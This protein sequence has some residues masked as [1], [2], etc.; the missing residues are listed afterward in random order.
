MSFDATFFSFTGGE[1]EEGEEEEERKTHIGTFAF[2]QGPH[3]LCNLGPILDG[4]D[5]TKIV[6]CANTRNDFIL[7]SHDISRRSKRDQDIFQ[8][9]ERLTPSRTSP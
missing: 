9:V 3:D 6:E 8:V 4:E 2:Q 7:K 1:E 5:F